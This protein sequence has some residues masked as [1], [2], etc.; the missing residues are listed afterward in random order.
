[1]KRTP[2]LVTVVLMFGLPVLALAGPK[3][4]V[5]A[6]TKAWA[7]AFNPTTSL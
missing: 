3:E 5:A 1:M 2:L 4:D 6:A 7:D